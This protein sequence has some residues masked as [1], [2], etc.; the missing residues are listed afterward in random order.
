MTH[1]TWR[2]TAKNGDQLRNPTLGNRVWA[3]FTFYE[4]LHY[5]CGREMELL[6]QVVGGGSCPGE[7]YPPLSCCCCCCCCYV[8]RDADGRSLTSLSLMML[9]KH[10][11]TLLHFPECRLH[12]VAPRSVSGEYRRDSASSDEHPCSL[13]LLTGA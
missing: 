3:T 4:S 13:A 6:Q 8:L 11:Q 7:E 12:V 9:Q 2:L 1:I 5:S 10:P